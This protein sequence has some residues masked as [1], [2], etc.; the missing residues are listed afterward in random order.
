[1][2]SAFPM[3]FHAY[4]NRPSVVIPEDPIDIEKHLGEAS[5]AICLREEETIRIFYEDGR[6][7]FVAM[8]FQVGSTWP[9]K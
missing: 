9:C 3:T 1:M 2:I 6:D 4:P 7:F 8:P 5:S